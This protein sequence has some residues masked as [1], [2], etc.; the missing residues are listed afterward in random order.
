MQHVKFLVPIFFL[1]SCSPDNDQKD[2]LLQEGMWRGNITIAE[3]KNMPFH[4]EVVHQ[5]ND[6]LLYI[7]NASEKIKLDDIYYF[8]DSVKIPLHIF[9][10]ALVAKIN[11]NEL[12]G[13]YIRYYEEDYKL[14]FQAV[15]GIDKRFLG[16]RNNP[17][18][19]MGTWDVTFKDPKDTTRAIGKFKANGSEVTGTF[20]LTTGDY[21]YLEGA[22]IND[23]LRLSTFDG[24]HAYLFHAYL[25]NDTLIKG[26]FWSGKEYHA[27]WSGI[28]DPTVTLPSADSLTYLKEGYDELTFSFPDLDSNMVSPEDYRG[29]ILI[30]QIF[31]SWCPNCMDETQFLAQWYSENKDLPVE[32]LGLAY[33]AKDDFDY[34]R[35]RVIR[36]KEKMGPQYKFLI[37]GTKDKEIASQ[38][39]PMLNKIVSFPTLIFLDA[40]GE[41]RKIHTGFSGPG[42]GEYYE[43][44][45]EDF[46]TTINELVKELQ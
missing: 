6:T 44:F 9:D 31:G 35:S 22:V 34:A 26:D 21:R 24:N 11:D 7:I 46:N 1:I 4:L 43:E 42:T 28:K 20:L 16:M 17:E 19:Y 40:Q 30:L 29:K 32:I 38:S 27:T 13:Y 18:K 10:A 39:L 25:E 41:V 36:M 14:P 3:N 23:T 12:N 15:Y 45:K 33:E 5:E 8:D 37:A 2:Q